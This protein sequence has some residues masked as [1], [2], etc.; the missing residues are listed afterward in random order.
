MRNQRPS[1]FVDRVLPKR[2]KARPDPRGLVFSWTEDREAGRNSDDARWS[3]G[4]A[5]L[6]S[7]AGSSWAC[8]GAFR[9]ACRGRCARVG[10]RRAALRVLLHDAGKVFAVDVGTTSW[11]E[12]RQNPRVIVPEQVKRAT[13]GRCGH[14]PVDITFATRASSLA[15]CST[16]RWLAPARRAA[17]R[18]GEA[19]F[20]AARGEIGKAA[21]FAIR[22]ASAL[23]SGLVRNARLDVRG[24]YRK[25]DH[26][27]RMGISVAAR[28]R[29]GAGPRRFDTPLSTRAVFAHELH[30][31]LL[32]FCCPPGARPLR[33]RSEKGRDKQRRCEAESRSRCAS[34]TCRRVG[35]AVATSR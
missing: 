29:N 26:R 28:A 20:E 13:D 5:I 6:G 16:R 7:R 19:Q 4:K 8:A 27:S 10:A 24:G 21:W 18:A 22:R 1:I 32:L 33:W 2:S 17:D 14:E 12:L 31:N 35:S 34:S 15:R 23:A 25:P 30:A 11:P 9:W 3:P